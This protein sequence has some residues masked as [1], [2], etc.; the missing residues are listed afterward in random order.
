VIVELEG[1]ASGRARQRLWRRLRLAAVLPIAVLG[2]LL[3]APVADAA[4]KAPAPVASGP[5]VVQIQSTIERPAFK[6][7]SFGSVGRYEKLTGTITGAVDPTDLR[8][9]SI[10]DLAHAP[11]DARGLV[12]YS[13]Q[14]VLLR[15]VD[16]SKGNHRVVYEPTNRGNIVSLFFL[17]NAP[18][19]NDPSSALEAGNGF[20]MDQGYSIMELAWDPT[21]S[22]NN[23]LLATYPVAKQV[24]GSSIVGPALEEITTDDATTAAQPYQL[25]YPAA[26]L[27]KSQA[28]LT[29]RVHYDD[30]PQTLPSSDWDYNAQGT[31]IQLTNMPFQLGALYELTYPAKD[32]VVAGLAFAAI[33]DVADFLR[34]ASVDQMGNPN[35][36]AGNAQEIYTFC[37]S[38]PCRLMHD[39]LRLGFNQTSG[40]GRA[41]DGIESL[42]AGASGGFFDY[43]FAQPGRSMRQHIGRWYPERQFPFT[44]QVTPDPVT[45][46]IDGILLRCTLTNTCPKIFEINTETEYWNKAA[47]LLTTDTQGN[48]LDLARTPNV[49]YY[50][51]S[52]LPHEVGVGQIP[53]C[54]QVQNPLL[55]N[56]VARALLVDLDQWVANGVA[57]PRNEVPRRRDGT[58][59]PALPQSGVG[60]PSIPNVTYNGLTTTGDLF[61]FGPLAEQGI[62]TTLPPQ[63]TEGAYPV[64]VPKTDADGNDVAGIHLPEIAV[65]VATYSGWNV[66]TA[67]YAGD[68]MCNAVGQKIAFP[69]DQATRLATGDPRLSVQE[70][71][72][73]HLNYVAKVTLAA[74]NLQRQRL[75][76]PEDVVRYVAAAALSNIGG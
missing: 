46:Q 74:A 9:S 59:V 72:P 58:L 32:P 65:P 51:L 43:R 11:R 35:P 63:I 22:Q 29:Y 39:F 34:N 40:G 26:T 21:A 5:G 71:Y 24:D 25:T 66:R 10:T 30:P 4:P 57:P 73:T 1:Q 50:L 52:S 56:P 41:V 14:Y 69:P 42:V 36:L 55:P 18:Q 33:R 61:D 7:R 16:L 3:A 62:L 44:D 48:D 12:E 6:G 23:P 76:L 45:G 49:R 47:S 31:T 53:V 28:S 64:F 20:L 68:D 17:N 37:Y 38:Q 13:V 60:F 54:Q 15:P 70:R 67:A 27:D 2:G 8:N 19:S 75:L